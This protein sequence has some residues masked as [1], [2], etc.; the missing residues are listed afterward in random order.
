[1]LKQIFEQKYGKIQNGFENGNL[2]MKPND[3]TKKHGIDHKSQPE[4]VWHIVQNFAK[5]DENL[6]DVDALKNMLKFISMEKRRSV[7]D[8]YMEV[9]TERLFFAHFTLNKEDILTKSCSVASL[10]Q[11]QKDAAVTELKSFIAGCK[12]MSYVPEYT[13]LASLIPLIKKYGGIK[14]SEKSIPDTKLL[15]A[16]RPVLKKLI[17]AGYKT[18]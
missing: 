12:K 18:R 10:S 14:V 4:Y 3:F 11:S 9:L 17:M 6:F 15:H 7:R 16:G 2:W 5:L 8:Y 13:D 1:M